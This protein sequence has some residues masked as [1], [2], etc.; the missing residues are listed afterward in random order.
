MQHRLSLLYYAALSLSMAMPALFISPAAADPAHFGMQ[1]TSNPS[2]QQADL[3]KRLFFDRRLS[4]NGTL[5]CAMCHIPE[6]GFTQN[7]LSTPVGLKGRSVK[8]NSPTLINVAYRKILFFDGREFTLE[9]QVWSP[10]LNAREMGNV[11]IGSVI[12]RLQDLDDYNAG[13][14]KIYADGITATTIGRA[15]A[16]YERTLIAAGSPFDQWY[17]GKQVSAVSKAVKD[18]FA[19]FIRHG[20]GN[21]HTVEDKHAQFTDDDFHNTGIGYARSML[22]QVRETKIIQLAE[23]ISIQTSGLFKGDSLNDLG[24]YEMTGLATDRWKYR[25]P[26]LRNITLTPP[27]MHDGSLSTLDEVIAFYVNGGIVND[28]LDE[29]I[30]PLKLNSSEIRQ[31]IL[32][33]HSLTSPH[34]QELIKDARTMAIGDY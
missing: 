23:T 27:Y 25:T 18:G 28:G 16:A 13:F 26:T 14:N 12:R 3:G 22:G 30:K 17:F 8:R 15:L 9:N 2:A 20:C 10:L 21:C 6:Q 1:A 34:V 7:Q 5:S 11:S 19:L 24:R 33:L 4:V 31:L 32:F 29:K